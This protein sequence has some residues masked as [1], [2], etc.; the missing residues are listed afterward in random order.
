MV[1]G[2]GVK[3]LRR[4]T[5]KHTWVKVLIVISLLRNKKKIKFVIKCL[6]YNYTE[7]VKDCFAPI[8][9]LKR[10]GGGSRVTLGGIFGPEG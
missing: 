2:V 4:N 1:G 3:R 9:I 8:C 10:W 5:E 7:L 6:M